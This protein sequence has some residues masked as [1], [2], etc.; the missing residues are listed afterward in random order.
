M[1]RPIFLTIAAVV[2]RALTFRVYELNVAAIDIGQFEVHT[3]IIE[4][5][6]NENP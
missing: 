5:L 1:F 3:S 4:K 6:D 2:L